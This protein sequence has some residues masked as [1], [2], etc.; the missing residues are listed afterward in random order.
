MKLYIVF[1]NHSEQIANYLSSGFEV[2]GYDRT[3]DAAVTVA[4]SMAEKP[5]A[6]LVLGSA[7]VTGITGGSLN[8][9][10]ALLE[11]LKKL[12]TS[13]PKSRIKLI[14]SNKIGDD[15]INGVASLGIYDIHQVETLKIEE[16]P[17][18]IMVEK[19][20][21]NYSDRCKIAETLP[22]IKKDEINIVSESNVQ[23]QKKSPID[24]V[25]KIFGHGDISDEARRT[26]EVGGGRIYEDV[27]KK[28]NDVIAGRSDAGKKSAFK[29]FA[30]A[31]RDRVKRRGA[32]RPEDAPPVS[33]ASTGTEG[34]ALGRSTEPDAEAIVEKSRIKLPEDFALLGNSVES[35]IASLPGDCSAVVIPASRP[36]LVAAIK[37]IRRFPAAS[38]LPIVVVGPCDAKECYAAGADECAEELEEKTVERVRA[39]AAR[40]RELLGEHEK[41][42]LLPEVSLPRK[43]SDVGN[44]GGLD[45][46]DDIYR[47]ALTGCYTRRYLLE[48]FFL[49]GPY[50]VAFIDLDNFKPV[51][52][53]LGHEAGDGVLA[54]FG[55]MLVESLKGRDVAVRWDGDEFI[56]ILLGTSLTGAEKVVE[57]LER[58]WE[59]CAPHTGNLK[60]GFSAG[61]AE[62]RSA[63][64][65]KETIEEADR[66]MYAVKKTRKAK[67]VWGPRKTSPLSRRTPEATVDSWYG[68]L[69][70]GLLVVVN[71]VAVAGGVSLLVWGAD[72]A[73]RFAGIHS[74]YLREA[75][76]VVEWF[77]RTVYIGI[78][79]RAV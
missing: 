73:A 17:G 75:A 44:V 12:R 19:D 47:D 37:E 48:R 57:N 9:G 2:I 26:V 39:K 55:K 76:K 72:C 45:Q 59:T 68:A 36:D 31:F 15:I 61:V 32:E 56:L 64:D 67:A 51:N 33:A 65:L 6:F 18:L 69:K 25:K 20:Y 1:G 41:T 43:E 5:D 74:P 50:A 70:K 4:E 40:M 3:L 38:S 63:A 28:L 54:A 14:L 10:K 78:T 58:E 8:Y 52:D 53:V 23:S 11:N 71:I 62:G 21:S 30:G 13:C 77:W 22:E 42:E 35:L 34:E 60:V 24:A 29:L 66:L 46:A 79:G 7:L 16:L 27:S 49:S